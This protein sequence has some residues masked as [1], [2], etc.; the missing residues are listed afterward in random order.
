MQ[1][2]AHNP[3][4]HLA[5]TFLS[6]FITGIGV[7]FSAILIYVFTQGFL[8]AKQKE[9]AVPVYSPPSMTMSGEVVANLEGGKGYAIKGLSQNGVTIEAVAFYPDGRMVNMSGQVKVTGKFLDNSCKYKDIFGGRCVPYIE[10][11]QITNTGKE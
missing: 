2:I 6:I 8:A 1:I 3:E 7:L 11:T 10:I 4:H 5:I 9:L